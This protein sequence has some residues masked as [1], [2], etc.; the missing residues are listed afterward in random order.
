VNNFSVLINQK[1][2]IG[3]YS[4]RRKVFC[5]H[6]QLK[7]GAEGKGKRQVVENLIEK[8]GLPDEQTMNIA[9]VSLDFVKAVRAELPDGGERVL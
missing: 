3:N 2:K 5:P 9:E 1:P 7:T 6:V 8:M 4:G